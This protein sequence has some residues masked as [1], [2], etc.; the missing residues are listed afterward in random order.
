MAGG[1]VGR[2]RRRISGSVRTRRGVDGAS[3]GPAVAEAS[4]LIPAPSGVPGRDRARWPVGLDGSRV[5]YAPDLDGDADPGEVVWA[6]V[7]FEEDP[8]QG[9][10]RPVLVIGYR[11]QLLVAVQLTS[12]SH[13][14]RTDADDWI[15][16]GR[17]V[18]LEGK[19]ELRRHVEVVDVHPL[20]DPPR[21][22]GPGRGS[23]CSGGSPGRGGSRLVL[24]RACER[25]AMAP[26][27]KRLM[28]PP[29]SGGGI[30]RGGGTCNPW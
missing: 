4:P 14:G 29:R 3:P 16:V 1:V 11:D 5:D 9:K 18:G 8:T 24:I 12:K 19:G 26:G 21:G 27:E 15:E 23:V 28:P 17:G 25:G 7:P 30:R 6:W 22:G 20:R 10:D 13:D 2:L